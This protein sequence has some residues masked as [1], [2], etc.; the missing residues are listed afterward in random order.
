MLI[1]IGNWRRIP[2]VLAQA[3]RRWLEATAVACGIA[4]LVSLAILVSDL[5]ANLSR[6]VP[7]P[8]MPPGFYLGEHHP[9]WVGVPYG[10][11]VPP[12]LQ[13]ETGPFPLIVF[14]HGYGE[15]TKDRF[16]A[17]GVPRSI[18]FRFGEHSEYGRFP[19][20]AFFPL[21]TTGTWAMES[22]EV[23]DAMKALDYVSRRHQIDSAR[24][25]LTGHSSGGNGVWRLA[26]A[27][28]SKWAAVAPVSSFMDPNIAAVKH[29]PVWIFHAAKDAHAPVERE[30]ALVQK[31]KESKAEVRYTEIPDK[32][33]VIWREVYDHKQ[34]YNWFAEKTR[35]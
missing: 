19:F 14:L 31:L 7:A 15:R 27:Y 13:R 24:I 16:F 5:Y 17:A 25:Y 20:V 2:S 33:H 35:K 30:R 12:H 22:D 4:A 28:P 11:Y 10:L 21:D 18:V 32:G 3:R 26:Q 23:K 1:V 34:L 8:H 6:E 29:I 9:S